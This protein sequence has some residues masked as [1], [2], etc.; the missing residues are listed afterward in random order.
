MKTAERITGILGIL[1]FA[2]GAIFKNLHLAG[3]GLMLNL[4]FLTFNF[5]YLP[6]NLIIHYRKNKSILYRSYLIIKFIAL[7]IILAGFTFKV[8][9]WPGAGILLVFSNLILP[10]FL[11]LYFIVRYK[12]L[13]GLTFHF[14]DLLIAVL[15]YGIYIFLIQS[16]ISPSA[17]EGYVTADEKFSTLNAGIESAN[18]LI[19]SS[20]DS[21]NVEENPELFG[22]IQSLK[23]ES[24]QLTHH[25]D[26]LRSDFLVFSAGSH[27]VRD[28]E[29]SYFASRFL[30]GRKSSEEFF[31]MAGYGAELERNIDHYMISI[32][33]IAHQFYLQSNLI[34]HGL[35]TVGRES[36]LKPEFW[37]ADEMFGSV[38][39][40]SIINSLSWLKQMVLLTESI[41]LNGLIN[42]LDLSQETVMLKELV[43]S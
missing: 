27:L 1:L 32:D 4:A 2:M 18:N 31:I 34:G 39:V 41:M 21:I 14:Q 17:M 36:Q 9:H 24:R 40:A 5:G 25:I 3:A 20:A 19:Y 26:T 22:A 29:L 7:F 10:V 43:L 16:T 38:N 13:G 28:K 37:W 8:L 35:E 42:Q 12:N 33:S 23:N 15:A 6:L 11:V 30:A